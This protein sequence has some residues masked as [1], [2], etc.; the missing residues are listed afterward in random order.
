MGHSRAL[1]VYF[2]HFQTIYRIK[3]VDFSG[4]RTRIVR[5]EGEYADHFTTATAPYYCDVTGVME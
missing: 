3:T 5:V 2:R 1:F 4:I